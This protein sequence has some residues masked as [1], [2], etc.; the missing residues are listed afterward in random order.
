M[1]TDIP[2]QRE[3]SSFRDPDGFIYTID[4]NIYR[5]ICSSYSETY[6]K[7]LESGLYSTLIEKNL[8]I[9]HEEV[10][11]NLA[12]SSE[13][14]WKV[15]K[16]E[17]IP[18][19]S[20]PYEWSFEQLKDAALLTLEIMKIALSYDMTLK[21]ASA[22]NVMFIGSRP[23]FIDTLSFKTYEKNK[24]WDGYNQFCRH[25]LA[26]LVLMKYRDLRLLDLFKTNIDG[27]P[28]DLAVK[29]MPLKAKSKIGLFAHLVLH[30][31]F[32][33]K[34]SSS[35]SK[36]ETLLSKESLIL[37]IQNLYDTVKSLELKYKEN[38]TEWGNYY[39]NTNYTN[40]AF[41]QKKQI[42]TNFIEKCQPKVVF[43]IGGNR[44]E[45]SRIAQSIERYTICFDID[46]IAVN[47]NYKIARENKE[48][49]ILPFVLDLNNPTSALGW[50]NKERKAWSDRGNPDLI[51]ALALIHHL[52]IS[53]NL[54]FESIA[55]LF[56]SITNKYLV[57]EF[58]PK[59][60]SKVQI[61]LSSRKDIFPNYTKEDFEISFSK[62]FRILKTEFVK[63]SE[64]CLYLM[65]KR[66]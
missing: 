54:S 52:A 43:D 8:L 42:I 3:F 10:D 55:E 2:K 53:N 37:L 28:L 29:L 18:F 17:K 15:I 60:D 26:P 12:Y 19:V 44:G 11:A 36:K 59:H 6:N 56:S 58:V 5:Q 16:V 62:K 23:I 25:F 21:D 40:V 33:N 20:Y 32:Q 4:N 22:F 41:E 46:P 49:N 57:I 24:P 63:D 51:T 9:R 14:A 39:N 13:N 27:I 65:E 1:N 34:Y 61:L 45:F 31:G 66:D 47:E 48:E 35:S 38:S 30:S 64:R 50:Q 7:F